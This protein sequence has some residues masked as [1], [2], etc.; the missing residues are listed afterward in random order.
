MELESFITNKA[1]S[2]HLNMSF[3]LEHF[4][5]THDNCVIKSSCP[6]RCTFYSRGYTMNM[7]QSGYFIL[8]TRSMDEADVRRE[9]VRLFGIEPVSVVLR[10][11]VVKFYHPGP[12]VL[13]VL[14]DALSG[15]TVH[16]FFQSG[17]AKGGA[18]P[19]VIMDKQTFSALRLRPFPRTRI[20]L[21]VFSSGA[22]GVAGLKSD[23]DLAR[24]REYICD[25]LIPL[26]ARASA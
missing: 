20:T 2:V 3:D 4:A 10:N 5:A 15:K 8:F 19:L 21:S 9:M 14:Y 25:T 11:L 12:I 16:D 24:T 18:V 7:Y 1:M 17:C 22:I 13:E 26:Y 23:E 6:W